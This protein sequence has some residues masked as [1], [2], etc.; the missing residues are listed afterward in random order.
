MLQSNDG[1]QPLCVH[2]RA[3][4]LPQGAGVFIIAYV[5]DFE[6]ATK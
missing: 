3:N 6:V 2:F 4:E 1:E 5:Q